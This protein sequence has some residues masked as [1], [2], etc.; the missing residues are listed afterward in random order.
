MTAFQN[1]SQSTP[2]EVLLK[3]Y[4]CCLKALKSN[5]NIGQYRY[6]CCL[7]AIFCQWCCYPLRTSDY[8]NHKI[9]GI[10]K[11]WNIYRYMGAIRKFGQKLPSGV[12]IHYGCIFNTIRLKIVAKSSKYLKQGDTGTW[13]LYDMAD[14]YNPSLNLKFRN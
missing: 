12:Y 7:N 3:Y 2:S 4:F 13:T 5:A 6:N 14:R 9:V 1:I 10:D 8:K 11:I